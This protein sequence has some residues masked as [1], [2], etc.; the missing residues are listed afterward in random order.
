MT[1]AA[2]SYPPKPPAKFEHWAK[3]P[4]ELG[5]RFVGHTFQFLR[6]CDGMVER[7]RK[8]H[9]ASFTIQMFGFPTLMVGEPDGVK[10]VL[11]DR[12]QNFSSALG[13]ATP[14]ASSSNKA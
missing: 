14:S 5:N 9:G 13:G 11:L 1:T 7:M 12:E 6:D 4:G 8:A 3:T 10:H 2:P